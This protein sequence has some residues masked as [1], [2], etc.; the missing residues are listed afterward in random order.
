MKIT[1]NPPGLLPDLVNWLRRNRCF[2]YAV[3]VGRC[4]VLYEVRHDPKEVEVELNF[5]LRAWQ[6]RHHGS[7][8]QLTA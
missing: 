1:V 2:A 3:G 7:M 6:M 4:C 8:A 5:C